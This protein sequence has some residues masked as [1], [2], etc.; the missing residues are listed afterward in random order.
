MIK[1]VCMKDHYIVDGIYDL[2]DWETNIEA[3]IS[4]YTL[5]LVI[6]RAKKIQSDMKNMLLHNIPFISK[7]T[8]DAGLQDEFT[9]YFKDGTDTD[10]LTSWEFVESLDDWMKYNAEDYDDVP[11]FIDIGKED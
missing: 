2:Y 7:I 8:Y 10:I 11:C 4:A 1:I 9:L 5:E 3:D 6:L